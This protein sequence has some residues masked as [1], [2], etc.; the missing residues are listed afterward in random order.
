MSIMSIQILLIHYGYLKFSPSA[1]VNLIVL[2][3]NLNEV[4]DLDVGA[5]AITYED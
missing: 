2:A 5:S 4:E 3:L 1:V